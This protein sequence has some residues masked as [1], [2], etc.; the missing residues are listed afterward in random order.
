MKLA[1]LFSLINVAF[2]LTE[3]EQQKRREEIHSDKKMSEE[4]AKVCCIFLEFS[5]F[6]SY[7][8]NKDFFSEIDVNI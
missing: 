6:F 4:E 3:R 7:F 1:G 2:G 8:F 5:Y